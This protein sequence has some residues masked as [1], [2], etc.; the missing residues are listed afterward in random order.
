[1]QNLPDEKLL[2]D[3]LPNSQV[4]NRYQVLVVERKILSTSVLNVEVAC[5]HTVGLDYSHHRKEKQV[6]KT[7]NNVSYV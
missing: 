4:S 3:K 1:M 7:Y 5:C 6:D 2:D